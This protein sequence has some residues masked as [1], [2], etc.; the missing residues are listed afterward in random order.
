M[1]AGRGAMEE[2]KPRPNRRPKH[3]K[4]VQQCR[5]SRCVDAECRVV[6]EDGVDDAIVRERRSV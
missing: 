6:V 2:A 1:M 5:I 3:N 4:R